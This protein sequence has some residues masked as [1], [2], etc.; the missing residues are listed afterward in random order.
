M[1]G[2][3]GFEAFL[4]LREMV[5]PRDRDKPLQVD[6]TLAGDLD[7]RKKYVKKYAVLMPN[8]LSEFILALSVVARK[9]N[10]SDHEITLIVPERLIPLCRLLSAIPI[11]PY[12]RKNS[13]HFLDSA[14]IVK[15]ADF[16]KL[17]LLPHSFSS[18]WFGFKTGVPCCRGIGAEQRNHFLTENISSDIISKEDHLTNEYSIVL[19]TQYVDP[20][21]WTGITID[22][23]SHYVGSVVLCPGSGEL[24]RRWNGFDELVKLWPDQHFI[25]L[26]DDNDIETSKNVGRRLPHRVVNLTGK[27]SLVEAAS[28]ISAA[29]VVIANDSG[30]MQLAG[31]VGTPVVGIFGGS[32]P[33]WRRPL[34]EAVR[35]VTSSDSP[36]MFC[37]KKECAKKN[38]KCM[39]TIF[40]EHVISA[41]MEIMRQ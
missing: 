15:E 8:W 13:L 38:Y 22:N 25:L 31:Y 28:I 32:S 40:P 12:N 5:A 2:T 21:S 27:T 17:Y 23:R 24:T 11:L 39:S 35:V 29:S 1:I 3:E 33:Q 6:D 10:D 20:S 19:E 7:A 34:G 4:Q 36:C 30:L 26:G 9:A 18:A 37:F 41:A 14:A 16:D